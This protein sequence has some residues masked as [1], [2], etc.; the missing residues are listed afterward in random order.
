MNKLKEIEADLGNRLAKVF[1]LEKQLETFKDSKMK[2][3]DIDTALKQPK[4]IS[5]TPPLPE[6]E[7][8]DF[9]SP[10]PR[11]PPK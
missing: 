8:I 3:E 1:A 11:T 6:K 7:S 9:P 2:P 10:T 5:F 4:P